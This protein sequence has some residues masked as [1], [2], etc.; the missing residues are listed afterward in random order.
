MEIALVAP[1]AELQTRSTRVEV[2]LRITAV[3]LFSGMR[4]GHSVQSWDHIGRE[5]IGTP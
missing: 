3:S 4:E 2:L 1:L 5:R